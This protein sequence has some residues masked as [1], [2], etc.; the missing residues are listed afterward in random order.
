MDRRRIIRPIEIS[1]LRIKLNPIGLCASAD[2]VYSW[3]RV[4]TDRI[5]ATFQAFDRHRQL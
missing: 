2:G 1:A 3:A 5:E 4:V